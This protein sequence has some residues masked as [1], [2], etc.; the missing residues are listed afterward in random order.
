MHFELSS[1]Q[2]PAP[3]GSCPSGRLGPTPDVTL[4][5]LGCPKTGCCDDFHAARLRHALCDVIAD[6]IVEVSRARW[7]SGGPWTR[8]IAQAVGTVLIIIP[9]RD[10]GA[11]GRRMRNLLACSHC[12]TSPTRGRATE[13]R[14]W[15]PTRCPLADRDFVARNADRCPAGYW[16]TASTFTVAPG[17]AS[18]TS[19]P[20]LSWPPTRRWL[21]RPLTPTGL[22][23]LIS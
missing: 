22:R 15:R 17:G 13:S 21:T 20:T 11:E 9:F 18:G 14:S 2:V 16:M 4:V 19:V 12:E 5:V 1:S 23:T 10:R 7:T 6:G 8:A 3:N